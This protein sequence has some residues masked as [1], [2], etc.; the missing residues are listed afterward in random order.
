M[1][2][3]ELG[4]LGTTSAVISNWNTLSNIT[5]DGI[6][7]SLRCGNLKSYIALSGWTLLR[8]RNLSA[9]K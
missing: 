2:A 5:E 8:R 7:Q 4:E 3:T 9:V 1:R 6:L